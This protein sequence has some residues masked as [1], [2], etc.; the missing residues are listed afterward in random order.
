MKTGA[1]LAIF[2]FVVVA[3]AHVLRLIFSVPITAGSWIVPQWVSLIGAVVPAGIAIL[4]WREN[5]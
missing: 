5:R 1:S 2:L 4:L 3:V